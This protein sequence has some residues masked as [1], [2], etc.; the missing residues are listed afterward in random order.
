VILLTGATGLLGSELCRQLVVDGQSVRILARRSSSMDALGPFR[1]AV[2]VHIGDITEPASL[3]SA[4]RGITHVYHVAGFVGFGGSKDRRLLHEINVTG[5]HNIVNACLDAGI[6]RL[7]H[8][9]SM[10]AFGRSAD[11]GQLIDERQTWTRSRYNS[12]YAHT[13]YL[14][15]LEIHRG[16]AEGLDAVMVNPALIFGVGR[17]GENTRRIAESVRDGRL[18]GIPAGGTNVVDVRDVAEGH[19]LAMARGRIG[20]RYFL[21]AENLSWREIIAILADAF[22]AS[23]PSFVVP[24]PLAAVMAVI[25]EA[26]AGVTRRTPQLTRETAL[27]ASRTYRYSNRKAVQE[28]G[29]SFRLFS[30]T[31]RWLA[32]E[33]G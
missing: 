30:E 21:G 27:N 20:E 31:A 4:T 24:P 25:S 7:V 6:E 23:P 32:E 9:S 19:R 3:A 28:L 17:P 29:C 5:T 18:P 15:E 8:T 10:A 2:E 16:I 26:W 12:E 22:N 1:S 14:A 13:K 11:G 33:L